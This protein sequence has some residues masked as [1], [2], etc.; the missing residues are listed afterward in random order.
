MNPI[1]SQSI[2]MA[3]VII[4]VL[5]FGVLLTAIA[6]EK[7]TILALIDTKLSMRRIRY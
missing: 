1:E 2:E 6:L 5:I 4:G 3:Y 7:D